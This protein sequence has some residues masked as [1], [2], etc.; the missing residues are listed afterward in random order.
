MFVIL[1]HEQTGKNTEIPMQFL[2]IVIAYCLARFTGIVPL[3]QHDGWLERLAG[4]GLLRQR[5]A[6]MRTLLLAGVPVLVFVLLWELGYW[7]SF[8]VGLLVLLYSLGRGDWRDALAQDERTLH[9]GNAEALWLTLESRGDLPTAAGDS[10]PAADVWLAWRRHAGRACLDGL[11]AVMFWFFVLGPAGALLYRIA[12]LYGR[13]PAVREGTLP[14]G[15]GWLALLDWLP[16]RY[17]ALC[18]CLAG[19][20][21]TGFHT[22]RQWMLDSTLPANDL[23]ARVLDAALLQEGTGL[24]TGSVEAALQPTAD[25]SPALRDLLARTELIGLVGLAVAVLVLQ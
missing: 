21:A 9:A 11:F 24:S 23:L 12:V 2:N 19:N 6:V 4:S 10:V 13:L 1:S 17:M 18:A 20:F 7:T 8:L 5:P 16:A 3:L 15:T 22:L 25:K 14:T